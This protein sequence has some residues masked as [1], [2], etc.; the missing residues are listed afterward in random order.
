M[1]FIILAQVGHLEALGGSFPPLQ[2]S[3]KSPKGLAANVQ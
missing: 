3:P 1:A 2:N